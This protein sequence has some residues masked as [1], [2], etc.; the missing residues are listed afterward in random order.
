MKYANIGVPYVC[1]MVNALCLTSGLCFPQF[2]FYA[3]EVKS[4]SWCATYLVFD[5]SYMRKLLKGGNGQFDSEVNFRVPSEKLFNSN[6]KY[7]STYNYYLYSNRILPNL[8]QMEGI[9]K[10]CYR[11]LLL[12]RTQCRSVYHIIE[13]ILIENLN[14]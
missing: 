6:D 9:S 12:F 2:H 4:Y 8:F 5:Q 7:F 11:Y 10:V 14:L 3:C 13:T 1:Q